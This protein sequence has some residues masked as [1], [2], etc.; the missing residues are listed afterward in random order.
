MYTRERLSLYSDQALCCWLGWMCIWSDPFIALV[1]CHIDR[2]APIQLV[3]FLAREMPEDLL[4]NGISIFQWLPVLFSASFVMLYLLNSF[5][6]WPWSSKNLE[7]VSYGAHPYSSNMHLALQCTNNHILWLCV[8]EDGDT[9]L[10]QFNTMFSKLL[11]P[12]DCVMME[13]KMFPD[14]KWYSY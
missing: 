12:K 10:I 5:M 1:L 6:T 8:L 7:V 13:H 4:H 11:L 14:L 3:F 2:A 9:F